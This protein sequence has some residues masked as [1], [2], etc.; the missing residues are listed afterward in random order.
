MHIRE[1]LNVLGLNN[2]CTTDDINKAYRNKAKEHH[3]DKGGDASYFVQINEAKN[4]LIGAKGH[5]TQGYRN[6]FE[7][8]FGH[9]KP[10]RSQ[11]IRIPEIH[12]S[13]TLGYRG[14]TVQR[15]VEEPK[16]CPDCHGL[17]RHG[18][19][20]VPCAGRGFTV[21]THGPSRS[22][23]ATKIFCH[24][25]AG[26]GR[27][28]QCNK[29]EG[30]GIIHTN[31]ETYIEIK[32]GTIQDTLIVLPSGLKIRVIVDIPQDYHIFSNRIIYRPKVS[33]QNMINGVDLDVLG[34]R[35]HLESF[36]FEGINI[37]DIYI[38][39]HIICDEKEQ[40]FFKNI[41]TNV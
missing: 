23:Y 37:G 3:P 21:K 7:T 2:N 26:T 19:D 34:E 5:T 13:L 22:H 6:I 31:Q 15:I 8:L 36:N 30:T 27:S 9:I 28:L 40:D 32:R 17:G 20:C 24:Y 12:I 14:G 11:S 35:V 38:R 33:L 29:C 41:I 18:D 25:C 39:P 4:V 16:Q 10:R 1:A